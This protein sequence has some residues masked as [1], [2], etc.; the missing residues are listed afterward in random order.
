MAVEK[1]T[2]Q[3]TVGEADM[4]HETSNLPLP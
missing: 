2:L 3:A 4:Q 1:S